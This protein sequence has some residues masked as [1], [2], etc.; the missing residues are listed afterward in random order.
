MAELADAVDSKS[1]DESLVG[2]TPTLGTSF[3]QRCKQ[4]GDMSGKGVGYVKKTE[5][6]QR[7]RLI[8]G[9][10]KAPLSRGDGLEI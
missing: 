8:L 2:S 10:F 3:Y 6:K 7:P 9:G 4:A 5:S 1:T